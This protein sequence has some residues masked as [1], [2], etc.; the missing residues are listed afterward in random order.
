[1]FHRDMEHLHDFYVIVKVHYITYI[2]VVVQILKIYV[3]N[4]VSQEYLSENSTL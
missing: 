3:Q 4:L 2:I 1:M